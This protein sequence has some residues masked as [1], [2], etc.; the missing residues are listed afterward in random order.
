MKN[1]NKNNSNYINKHMSYS[2]EDGASKSL[3]VGMGMKSVVEDLPVTGK[4]LDSVPQP[5]E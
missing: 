1:K 5:Q 4:P 2:K 3:N